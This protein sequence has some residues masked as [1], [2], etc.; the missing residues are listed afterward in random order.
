[1]FCECFYFR[2][3]NL[4]FV[5]PEKLITGQSQDERMGHSG[6]EGGETAS[7]ENGEVE[8]EER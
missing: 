6:I 2:L 4:I 1:M 5:K 7:G 8:E 3:I